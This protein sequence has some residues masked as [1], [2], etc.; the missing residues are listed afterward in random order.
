[1]KFGILKTA[2]ALMAMMSA[3]IKA[4]NKAETDRL[5]GMISSGG[6]R[7]RGKGRGTPPRNFIGKTHSLLRDGVRERRRR[8]RQMYGAFASERPG[9]PK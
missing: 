1:M 3:A 6:Y 5:D 2:A 8:M 9:W 7:Y 4:G